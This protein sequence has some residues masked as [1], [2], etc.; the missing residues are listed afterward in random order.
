VQ[1]DSRGHDR[2]TRDG[3]SDAIARRLRPRIPGLE[4]IK[5]GCARGET[6][7]TL[8]RGGRCRYAAGSQLREATTFLRAHHGHVALVT[9]NIGDNDVEGCIDAAGVDR[10][11]VAAG[12]AAV[13]SNLPPIAS[14][15]RSSAG[16][17]VPVV[18]VADYDQFLALWLRGPGGRAVAQQSVS[19]IRQLN[20]AIDRA[21]LDAGLAAA[22]LSKRFATSDLR[23]LTTLKGR[24]RVP[25][26]VQRICVWTW[27]CSPQPIGFDDH[28]N[29]TGYSVIAAG[30]LA[31]S[32]VAFAGRR[33]S[34]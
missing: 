13:K 20:T 10:P 25:R 30:V 22:D 15:L 29:T 24:G 2:T 27:A 7:R 4:L 8:R 6:S 26:G 23:H 33:R 16:A 14:A 17:G 19:V 21:F 18:G 11:C 5:L 28:A 1:P 3:Y 31:Q 32:T 12:M 9:V 34:Q